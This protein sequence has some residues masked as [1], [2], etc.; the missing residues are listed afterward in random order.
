MGQS[1]SSSAW[2]SLALLLALP[3][4]S[5]ADT[6]LVKHGDAWRYRKGAS[7]AQ[8]DWKTTPDSGLNASWLTGNGGFGYADNTTETALCQTLL[9]DMRGGYS[10]LAARKSFQIS[11][12][13]D[14]AMRLVLTMD[15]D[16]GF[17]ACYG[18]RFIVPARQILAT[19]SSDRLR[20][21]ARGSRVPREAQHT[22]RTKPLR[23]VFR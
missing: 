4:L 6:P 21:A 23:E 18:C 14:P 22:A 17:I 7:A 20:A 16:D 1:T 2:Q 3:L 10:T 9:A 11:S 15:F 5:S 12:T 19:R 8:A 13:A